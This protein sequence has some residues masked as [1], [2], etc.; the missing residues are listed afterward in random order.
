MSRLGEQPSSPKA[1]PY[2]MRVRQESV[3]ETRLRIT[4]ATMRLHERIGPAATTVS[5]IADEAG[6]TRL[7][8]Y[9]HF[10]DERALFNACSSHYMAQHQ[11]PDATAWRQIVDPEERLP[12]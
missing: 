10:P 4:E 12:C 3:D 7:T 2:T 9:R 1:R 6:V 8:V 11:L 5:A